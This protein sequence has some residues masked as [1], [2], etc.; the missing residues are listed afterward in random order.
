MPPCRRSRSHH[1]IELAVTF[2]IPTATDTAP[3]PESYVAASQKSKLRLPRCFDSKIPRVSR[4]GGKTPKRFQGAT[5]IQK[6][7]MVRTTVITTHRV[8]L[9]CLEARR[10]LAGAV[11]R[12]RL[13]DANRR[14][15]VRNRTQRSTRFD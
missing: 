10:E 4:L 12:K 13:V 6:A 14:Y 15:A 1:Q 7:A 5:V 2:E 11:S 9:S 3:P 8:A